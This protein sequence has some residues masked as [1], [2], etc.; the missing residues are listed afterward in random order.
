MLT[1]IHVLGERKRIYTFI[2]NSDSRLLEEVGDFVLDILPNLKK[3]AI[4]KYLG[5]DI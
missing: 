5:V 4:K 3:I 2:L 1:Q